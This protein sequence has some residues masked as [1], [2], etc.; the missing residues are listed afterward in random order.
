M[1]EGRDIIC[2]ANDWDSDPLSKKHIMLRLARTNRILWVNSIGNRKPAATTHDVKRVFKKLRDFSKGY[3]Q[4]DSSVHV[5]S[6]L[7]LPF[8]GSALARQINRR[9]LGWSLRAVCRRLGFRNPITWTFEP[10]S[11]EVA[12]SL[13]ES[14][15]VYHCVDEF[16]EFSGTDKQ[17]LLAL[18]RRLIEK[19]DCVIVSSDLLL[20]KKR[21]FNQRTHLVTHGVDVTHFRTA[22][23]SN[24]A[25]P[26]EIERL[27]GPIVGF[28]GL[29]A[30]WIDLDLI[31][32][33]AAE[34]PSWN[35]VLI[36]K[37]TTGLG[38]LNGLPNIHCLGPKPYAALPAY[39]KGF[40]IA[41]LPFAVNELTLAANPL[42]LREYL[43]AGLPVVST[44][45]PEAGRLGDL[46]RVGKNKDDFIRQLQTIV[47]GG[48]TGP[49]SSISER[50]DAE[51][52]DRKVEE[53]CRIVAGVQGARAA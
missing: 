13:G 9:A 42:K 35:V 41:I 50:M 3:R 30:D 48:I 40:D 46:V 29:I 16:S 31:R 32:A 44:A 19:S 28:F 21:C 49:H 14:T 52:W 20:A 1:I 51:S 2:F 36:G 17:A 4:V 39:A 45:I 24:T 5:F 22:C 18:E 26:L 43:A 33:I 8:H 25:V 10:A 6:P 38:R 15:L 53:L 47:D 23:D 12:G 37:A 34:R 27:S 11:A 7:A